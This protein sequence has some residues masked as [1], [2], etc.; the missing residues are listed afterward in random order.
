[1]ETNKLYYSITQSA[2]TMD[3]KFN[4]VRSNSTTWPKSPL[5]ERGASAISQMALFTQAGP[6]SPKLLGKK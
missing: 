6:F 2:E 1:M 3:F 5:P 4:Y